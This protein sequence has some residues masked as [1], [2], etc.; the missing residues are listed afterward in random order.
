MIQRYAQENGIK[1][2][3]TIAP[4]KN[5]LYGEYM[6]YYYQAFRSGESNLGRLQKYLDSEGVNYVDLYGLLK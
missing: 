1:F 2:V 5:S 6:P 4:N 3:F